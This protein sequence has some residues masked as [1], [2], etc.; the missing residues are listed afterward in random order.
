[1]FI[2]LTSFSRGSTVLASFAEVSAMLKA[3][4]DACDALRRKAAMA[5]ASLGY[6][7]ALRVV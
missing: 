4:L 6:W 3:L 5:A 7:R 1:M 2:D